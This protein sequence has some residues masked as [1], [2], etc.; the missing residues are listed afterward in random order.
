MKILTWNVWHGLA[1]RGVT[2]FREFES[3][4]R[5]D[6]RFQK[7]IDAVQAADAD[8]VFLQEVNPLQLRCREFLN[9]L[10]EYRVLASQIDQSGVRVFGVGLPENLNTGLLTLGKSNSI[11]NQSQAQSRQLSG[12]GQLMNRVLSLQLKE[13][14]WATFVQL[15]SANYGPL[16]LANTHLHHGFEGFS[17]LQEIANRYLAEGRISRADYSS[18]QI[19][20]AKSQTRRIAEWDQIQSTLKTHFAGLPVIFAGDLN[21]TPDTLLND[22]I[23]N[24][25]FTDLELIA[26]SRTGPSETWYPELN[27]DNH[28]LQKTFVYPLANFGNPEVTSVYRMFDQAPRRIDYVFASKQLAE[29]YEWSRTTLGTNSNEIQPSDHFGLLYESFSK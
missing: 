5:R 18:M 29:S 21:C 15:E 4:E 7:L 25:G 28:D 26:K 27:R 1:E 23:L 8:F 6:F 19:E 12:R 22:R 24:S 3:K 9:Q 16:V 17:K 10:P 11:V 14:R 20:F 2:A 13:S